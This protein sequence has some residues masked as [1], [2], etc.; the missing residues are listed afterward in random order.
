MHMHT[1]MFVCANMICKNNYCVHAFF[2]PQLQESS[3]SHIFLLNTN[4]EGT[5]WFLCTVRLTSLHS[6]LTV[7]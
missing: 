7:N 2:F 4:K 1:G 3:E 6:Y 5:L